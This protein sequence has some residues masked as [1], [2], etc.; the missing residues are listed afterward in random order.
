MKQY[1][2]FHPSYV[3]ETS[4]I[5][6]EGQKENA[7]KHGYIVLGEKEL[8]K[9][10]SWDHLTIVGHS[11]A[12]QSSSSDSSSENDCG[13]Y[14]QGDTADECYTRLRYSGLRVPPKVLSLECCHAAID[15][16]I[17]ETLSAHKFFKTSLV[18]ANPSGVGRNPETVVW[19]GFLLDKFGR[20]VM[21]H[22]EYDWVFMRGGGERKSPNTRMG[23]TA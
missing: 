16:G 5:T 15:G 7:R 2:W 9:V 3:A 6:V 10:R 13:L 20:A 19:S 4:E 11:T 23:V 12:P 17:A 22:G 21:F 1:M 14:I 18:E 8:G